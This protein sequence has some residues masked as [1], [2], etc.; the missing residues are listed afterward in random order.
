MAVHLG[1]GRHE[2]ILGC[3]DEAQLAK[4]NATGENVDFLPGVKVAGVECVVSQNARGAF[5]AVFVALPSYAFEEGLRDVSLDARRWINLAKGFDIETLE[6]GGEK[7]ERLLPG[8]IVMALSG[9]TNARLV[10]EETPCAM[11][12]SGRIDE[13]T[14]ALQE[15]ISS[16]AMR[17]Y[18]SAD[19]RGAELGG[20]L[21]NVFAVAAGVCDGLG[22]GD[23]AKAGLLTRAVAEMARLGMAL[24]GQKETFWGLTGVGD[25]MATSYGVWSRNRQLGERVARGEDPRWLTTE[26]GLTAEGYRT[27]L[28]L[29]KLARGKGVD[30]PIVE[31][32]AAI[33]Y[34]NRAPRDIVCELMG[35][36]LKGE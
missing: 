23:N 11:V 29:R 21:K 31:A 7:L 6:S 10:A 36:T 18:T 28:A 2:V 8:R 24:G 22:L 35:R 4:I 15:A 16:P 3:R 17:L 14:R 19:R 1:R 5:D 34:E 12:V 33:L 13:T 27:S 32:V 26:G 30:A 9:P 20:A 25:L